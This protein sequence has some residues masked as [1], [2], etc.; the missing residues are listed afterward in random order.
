MPLVLAT[1]AA[2]LVAAC[3][4]PLVK[5]VTSAQASTQVQSQNGARALKRGDLNGALAAYGE[6]LAAAESV[7]DFDAGGTQLLNLAAVHARLGQLDAAHARLDRIVNAPQRY[8]ETLLGQAAA[9][10]A[11]LY[12]DAGAHGTAL[13]WADRAHVGCPEP[14]NLTPAMTNLRAFIALERGEMQRAAG[15][16]TRSAE[17]AAAAGLHAEQA[18]ALRLAGRAETKLG[19]APAAAQALAQALQIDRELGLPERIALDLM[20]AGEN[21]ERRGQAAAARELYERALRVGEAAGLPKL[22]D[23]LRARLGATTKTIPRQ[24]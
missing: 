7:E 17:L 16:A 13:S 11:L 23:T 24:P 19:N 2:S 22:V 3:S 8:S 1:L 9:R 15:M 20:Y 21:E 6:A 12:L 14:C 5:P 18:N 4:S 10:K